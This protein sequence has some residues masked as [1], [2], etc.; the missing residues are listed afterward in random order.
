MPGQL[1][2]PS[3]GT[4]TTDHTP[5]SSLYHDWR[6]WLP[7]LGDS[8]ATDDEK[9]RLIETLMIIVECFADMDYDV[10]GPDD[11]N[12]KETCGQTVNLAAAL[13]AAVLNSRKAATLKNESKEEV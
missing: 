10:L 8:D 9:R 13:Q 12:A 5:K 4:S 2:P 6:D 1:P 7:Y 11:P 3:T